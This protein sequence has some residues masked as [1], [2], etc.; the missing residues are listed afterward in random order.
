MLPQVFHVCCN[1]RERSASMTAIPV[2][3]SRL[4]VRDGEGHAPH[5]F[6][7]PLLSVGG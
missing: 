5:T 7:L 4:L 6:A 1:I 2:K 3:V